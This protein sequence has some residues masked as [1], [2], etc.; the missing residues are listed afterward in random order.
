MRPESRYKAYVLRV[1]EVE[2]DQLPVVVA[3]LEDC[4]TNQRQAFAQLADLLAFLESAAHQQGADS[5]ADD[6]VGQKA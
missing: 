1:W 5:I 2:R 4:Q 3:S 6:R